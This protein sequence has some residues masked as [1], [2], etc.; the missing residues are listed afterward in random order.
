MRLKDSAS[1]SAGYPFRGKIPEV[2][3]S[4]IIVVQMKD[5]SINT[6]IKWDECLKTELTGKKK[7]EWLNPTDI[8]VAARGNHYYAVQVGERGSNV[9]AIAAPHFFVVRINRF[10]VLPEYL[11]WLLNQSPC[12]KYLEQNAEGSMSKS[13]RRSVLEETPIAIPPLVKQKAIVEMVRALNREQKII[14]QLLR[15]GEQMMSLIANDLLNQ[16]F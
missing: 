2:Q 4:S 6:G 3:D 5:A 13:I 8:L 10:D 1:I 9:Q 7:P 14:E 15:N 11:T 16:T 12:Q